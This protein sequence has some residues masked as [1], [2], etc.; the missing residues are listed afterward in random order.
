MAVLLNAQNFDFTQAKP[1]GEDIRFSKMDGTLLPYNIETW[2][3]A[4][5]DRRHL[6]ARSTR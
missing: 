5:Q 6:G 3:T 4:G 1:A 2:D